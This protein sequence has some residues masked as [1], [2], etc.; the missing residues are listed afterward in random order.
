MKE[1]YSSYLQ[2][3]N[4]IVGYYIEEQREIQDI[5]NVIDKIET[6][7]AYLKDGAYVENNDFQFYSKCSRIASE[8]AA[9]DLFN[10][11]IKRAKAYAAA[12]NH[13]NE[14]LNNLIDSGIW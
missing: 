9:R 8:R 14:Q 10:N 5:I 2:E 3:L 4:E 11:D 7:C 13:F 12:Y 6:V 1:L